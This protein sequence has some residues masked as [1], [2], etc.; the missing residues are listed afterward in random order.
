MKNK[1]I[2]EARTKS[3]DADK[4]VVRL[5]DEMRGTVQD[6][7]TAGHTSMNSYIVQSI[8]EKLDRENRQELLINALIAQLQAAGGTVP[9]AAIRNGR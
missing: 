6:A 8:E 4:F 2:K 7:A 1:G 5:P 3:R 9:P